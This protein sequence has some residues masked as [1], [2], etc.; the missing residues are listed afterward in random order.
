MTTEVAK[1]TTE[2]HESKKCVN[3]SSLTLNPSLLKLLKKTWSVDHRTQ[4]GFLKGTMCIYNY[5]STMRL[6]SE[7]QIRNNVLQVH[8]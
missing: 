4:F 3:L 6:D 8:T 5:L 1:S 7:L 2:V